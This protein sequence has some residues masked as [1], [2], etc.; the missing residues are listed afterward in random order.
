MTSDEHGPYYRDQSSAMLVI[1]VGDA[2]HLAVGRLDSKR[3]NR[4]VPVSLDGANGRCTVAVGVLHRPDHL[5][6]GPGACCDK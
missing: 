3:Q 4:A 5:R 1:R 6:D 2:K